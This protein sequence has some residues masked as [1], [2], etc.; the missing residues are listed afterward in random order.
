MAINHIL[1][2]DSEAVFYVFSDDIKYCKDVT[3]L[4][5][6]NFILDL[7]EIDSLYLMSMCTK[8]GICSNSS[9]SW[10]GGYLND[11]NDKMVIYPNRW[12]N[13]NWEVDIGWKGCYI[14]NIDDFTIDKKI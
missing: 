14:M 13:S 11:N 8:G 2:I 4:T 10:W 1:S 5:S 3:Y 6:F 9:F 12:F 7:D